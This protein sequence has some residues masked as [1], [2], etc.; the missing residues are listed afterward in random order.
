MS[1]SRLNYDEGA[2]KQDIRQS[3]GPGNYILASHQLCNPCYPF[4]AHCSSAKTRQLSGPVKSSNWCGLWAQGLRHC[5]SKDPN[6]NYRPVCPENVCQSGE[7]CGQGVVG[8]CSAPNHQLK[9]GERH[10]DSN[11]RHFRD[12]FIPSEDTRTTN[13]ACNLR[14]TGFD[15]WEWLC[16]DP[17]ARVEI[18]FDWNINN[19]I[20]VR[21]NHR[22]CIPKPI[23]C[24]PCLPPAS[25]LKC[26]DTTPVC[27]V[28]EKQ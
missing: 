16:K 15:R 14:G 18:P 7:L 26:T 19:R 2:Y 13:P 22:P 24:G 27:I 3:T 23:E 28:D 21:D 9:D 5:H 12:C 4:P 20:V 25:P 17:Q 1:F 6:K 8:S 11:L 10:V